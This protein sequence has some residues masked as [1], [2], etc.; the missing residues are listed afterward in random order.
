MF[1]LSR[2]RSRV[3]APSSPPFK[4]I[5]SNIPSVST[6]EVLSQVRQQPVPHQQVPIREKLRL[7][8]IDAERGRP[9]LSKVNGYAARADGFEISSTVSAVFSG[10]S[11]RVAISA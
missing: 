9:S 10:C 2:R 7:Y 1:G 8:P 4:S 11:H 6:L 5:I 3:R